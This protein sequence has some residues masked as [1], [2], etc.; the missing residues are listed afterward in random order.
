M[1]P[2]TPFKSTTRLAASIC[3]ASASLLLTTKALA[4]DGHG[5][6]GSHWHNTD[7][8]GFVTLALMVGAA[9]C[10]SKGGK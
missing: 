6:A 2:A 8:W 10:L 9:I 1:H 4:H 5:L 3:A 7:A